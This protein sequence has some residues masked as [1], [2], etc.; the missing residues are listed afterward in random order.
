[1]IYTSGTTGQPKGALHAHR[2]LLGHLPG[3]EMPHYPFPQAGDRYWTPADWAWAGGLLDVLLPSLHHGVPVVAHRIDK[4]DPDDA[5]A[6]MREARR[7]QRLHPADGAAH[8]ARGAEPARALRLQAAQR[9]LRRRVARRRGAGMGQRGL[10]P[11]PSTNSTARPNAIWCSSSCAALGVL[12]PGAIGKP[13]PGHIVAVIG[14]DGAGAEARRARPDRGQA[15]RSGDVPANTGASPRR[16]AT[17]SS[18]TG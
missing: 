1:M 5:F 4:F 16:R 6:L 15:A 2:V 8:D 17:S 10:R 13:V 7:A 18:A 3:V 11:R 14:P 9:R 12:K